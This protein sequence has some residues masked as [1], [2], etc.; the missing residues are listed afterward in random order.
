MNVYH[1]KAIELRYKGY[2]TKEIE[3][4]L[5]GKLTKGTLDNYFAYDGKLYLPFLDFQARQDKFIEEDVRSEFKSQ[6]KYAPKIMN[7]IL[8][9][10]L[11]AHDYIAALHIV[12]EQLDRAGLVT[13]KKSEVNVK[14][15]QQKE[16]TYELYLKECARLGI[17]PRS[18]LRIS[19]TQ[20]DPN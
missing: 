3:K 1:K 7:T 5:G 14:D 2:T 16:M 11:K 15:D 9:Q 10:A 13:I 17:D 12:K 4:A 19:K 18:G 6:A 8:Q 20:T